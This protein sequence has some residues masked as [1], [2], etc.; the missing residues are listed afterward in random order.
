MGSC[1]REVYT[2]QD[3]TVCSQSHHLLSGAGKTQLALQLSLFVQA[4]K[5]TGGLAASACY[6]TTSSKLPTARLLQ[7]SQTHELLSPS[8]CSLEH[9]HTISIP[10]SDFL[11]LVLTT[12]LPSFIREQE[13]IQGKKPVKLVIIDALA[14][15]FHDIGK[16]TTSTLVERKQNI[17]KISASLHE[18]ASSYNIAIVV[19]NEVVDNFDN[20]QEHPGSRVPGEMAFKQ[21][22]RGFNNV[23]AFDANKK[24][25]LGPAWTNQVNAK[26]M[27][28]RTGRRK[29]LQDEDFPPKRR[30]LL[31]PSDNQ[32]QPSRTSIDN[33]EPTLIR[34]LRIIFSSVSAPASLDFIVSEGGISVLQNNIH[35]ALISDQSSPFVHA[36]DQRPEGPSTGIQ[37]ELET[38]STQLVAHPTNEAAAAAEVEDEYDK[39]WTEDTYN[40]FDWDALEQVLTQTV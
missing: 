22:S 11:Q 16:T 40:D 32:N 19:L 34:R 7:I 38:T 14:E 25:A 4:P 33:Q 15:L 26:I 8:F 12:I 6:L 27:L 37:L 20:W 13:T 21:Q 2:I 1:R 10:T 30:Q 31:E 23:E 35:A 39:L 28:S 9:V 18:I 29:H 24:A 3:A 5:E 36:S 17:A